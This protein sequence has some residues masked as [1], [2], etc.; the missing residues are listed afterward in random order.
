ME[1]KLP[2]ILFCAK[3]AIPQ[4]ANYTYKQAEAKIRGLA[5]PT[6][7]ILTSPLSWRE[8]N[9]IPTVPL[10]QLTICFGNLTNAFNR[11]L[12]PPSPMKDIYPN[13]YKQEYHRLMFDEK[14]FRE[15]SLIPIP[16][17]PIWKED[18]SFDFQ[19]V[20]YFSKGRDKYLD[21][22]LDD[23]VWDIQKNIAASQ[24]D[25][26]VVFL[27]YISDPAKPLKP[28]EKTLNGLIY[29]TPRSTNPV[30]PIPAFVAPQIQFWN[31]ASFELAAEVLRINSLETIDKLYQYLEIKKENQTTATML[32][33]ACSQRISAENYTVQILTAITR[34]ECKQVKRLV[35]ICRFV[36]DKKLQP[37]VDYATAI[38]QREATDVSQIPASNKDMCTPNNAF[39]DGRSSFLLPLRAII[40]QLT[41]EEG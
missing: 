40:A 1:L 36:L 13:N 39:I 28:N 3:L 17:R 10:V 23:C 18:V 9:T 30:D 22:Y 6:G 29:Y 11:W 20:H 7:F 26:T 25:R 38:F 34:A 4:P 5:K 14:G 37:Q 19:K 27:N 16:F 24:R 31:D 12:N 15:G 41:N 33:G 32:R 8:F 2:D 21:Q 35:K